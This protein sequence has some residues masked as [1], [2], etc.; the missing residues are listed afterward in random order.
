MGWFKLS[1][2]EEEYWGKIKSGDRADIILLGEIQTTYTTSVQKIEQNGLSVE[3][4][5]LGS[6][7]LEVS[8]KLKVSINIYAASGVLK[9]DTAVTAQ[10]WENGRF[11]SFAKPRKIEYIQRR[12]FLRLNKVLSVDYGVVPADEKAASD[13]NNVVINLSAVTRNIS[14]GGLQIVGD[15]PFAPGSLLNLVLDLEGKMITLIGRVLEQVDISKGRKLLARIQFVMVHNEDKE[16]IRKY[17]VENVRRMKNN[18][19]I[20]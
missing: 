5:W 18:P 17:I 14:E 10:E 11:I 8:L 13:P 7:V 15:V 16:A 20:S 12:Q 1:K 3:T 9:F 6:T 19:L 4:P 2:E